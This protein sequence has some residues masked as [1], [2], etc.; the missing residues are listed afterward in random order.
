MYNSPQ[1]GLGL[2][3]MLIYKGIFSSYVQQP[4]D[5]VGFGHQAIQLFKNLFEVKG[6]VGKLESDYC[7]PR[8]AK[9]RSPKTSFLIYINL[10][11]TSGIKVNSRPYQ[12]VGCEKNRKFRKLNFLIG[13]F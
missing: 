12:M 5:W 11:N 6:K 3:I 7:H 10:I 8:V 1:T 2:G 4:L 9:S 13:F